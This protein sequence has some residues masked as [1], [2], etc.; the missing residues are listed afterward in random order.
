MGKHTINIHMMLLI[1]SAFLTGVL[2]FAGFGEALD[3]W[4]V[5]WVT[6][7]IDAYLFGYAID[8]I[9]GLFMERH[10]NGEIVVIT[11]G[12]LTCI[13]GIPG[14]YLQF[15]GKGWDDLV[16]VVLLFYFALPLLIT[17][18]ICLGLY[19]VRRKCLKTDY[20]Q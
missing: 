1:I 19:L 3:F 11:V 5:L 14:L 9:A 6:L 16:A 10:L 18:V 15:F 20:T 2:I 12:M 4:P 13:P 8:F 7:G 17:T